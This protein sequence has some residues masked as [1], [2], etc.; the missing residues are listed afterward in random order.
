MGGRGFAPFA[1]K[2]GVNDNA[3]KMVDASDNP[4]QAMKGGSHRLGQE[5]KKQK[6]VSYPV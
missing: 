2:G 1:P 3:G 6:L 5:H 4:E